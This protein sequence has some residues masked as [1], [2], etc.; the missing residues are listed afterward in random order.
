MYDRRF[1]HMHPIDGRPM[2]GCESE[3]SVRNFARA[4]ASR[5]GTYP[6]WNSNTL[7][8]FFSITN[9][10]DVGP[11]AVNMA[12]IK[13]GGSVVDDAVSY[14]NRGKMS[15]ADKDRIAASN[16]Q[17]ESWRKQDEMAS[18]LEERRPDAIDYAEYLDKRRRGVGNVSVTV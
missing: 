16:Q 17:K 9:T 12:Q 5:T 1:P 10:P 3:A 2:P 18:M 14:I 13:R 11:M 4:V 6:F 7:A 8:V 15:R